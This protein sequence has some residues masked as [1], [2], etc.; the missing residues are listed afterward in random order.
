[1]PGIIAHGR[2]VT[3]KSPGVVGTGS[4]LVG[5]DSILLSPTKEYAAFGWRVKRLPGFAPGSLLASL[6]PCL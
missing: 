5:S 2:N 3:L 4:N 1:M 6:E